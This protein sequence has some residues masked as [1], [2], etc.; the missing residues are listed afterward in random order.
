MTSVFPNGI[1]HCFCSDAEWGDLAG[2][3]TPNEDP[4][5]PDVVAPRPNISSP[6]APNASAGAIGVEMFKQAK[7]NHPSYLALRAMLKTQILAAIVIDI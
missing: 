4:S 2:N 1:I 5:L 6:T 3:L 7:S